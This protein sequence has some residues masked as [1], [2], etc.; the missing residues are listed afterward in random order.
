MTRTRNFKRRNR[1][2]WDKGRKPTVHAGIDWGVSDP[3]SEAYAFWCK[4]CGHI[5]AW[6]F[7]VEKTVIE[8]WEAGGE[9]CADCLEKRDKEELK[10]VDPQH[11]DNMEDALFNG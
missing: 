6:S 4:G 2:F 3:D 5:L 9:L 1:P 7:N 11:H 10:V 8:E